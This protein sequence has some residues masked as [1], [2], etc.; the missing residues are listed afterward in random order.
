MTAPSKL[1]DRLVEKV[2]GPS[3]RHFTPSELEDQT[4]A[5]PPRSVIAQLEEGRKQRRAAQERMRKFEGF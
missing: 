2:F 3:K 4:P 1:A 5:K